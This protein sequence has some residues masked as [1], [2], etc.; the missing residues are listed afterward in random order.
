MS[1]I[2]AAFDAFCTEA[3]TAESFYVVLMEEV[4]SWPRC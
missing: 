4:C 2:R 1:Y 3:V